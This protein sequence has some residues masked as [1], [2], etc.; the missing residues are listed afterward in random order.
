[1]LS[2][3]KGGP[4][5]MGRLELMI[6][7]EPPFSLPFQCNHFQVHGTSGFKGKLGSAN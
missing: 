2:T 6:F 1:M 5:R 7:S 4:L 3:K